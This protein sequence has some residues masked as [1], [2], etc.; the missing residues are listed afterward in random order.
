MLQETKTG[1]V[2]RRRIAVTIS[3]SAVPIIPCNDLDESQRFY[4]RLGFAVTAN[5]SARG[6]MILRRPDGAIVHL[7]QAEPGWVD[8]DRNAYAIYLYAQDV[9]ELA[10]AFRCKSELRPWGLREFGVSDP[11][12]TLVRIGWPV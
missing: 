1:L 12:G 7:S 9:D 11:N 4:E 5:Y 10:A 2:S 3:Q 8:P 6:Y